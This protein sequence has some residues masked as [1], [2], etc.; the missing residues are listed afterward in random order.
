MIENMN[1]KIG[2]A[3]GLVVLLAVVLLYLRR[4]SSVQ[5]EM[6]EETLPDDSD[7]DIVDEDEEFTII[8]NQ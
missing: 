3:V 1:I 8:D 4:G 7:V 5:E 2:I 6:E